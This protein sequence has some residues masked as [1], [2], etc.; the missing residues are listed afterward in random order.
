M[1]N[2]DS[3]LDATVNDANSGNNNVG[4]EIGSLTTYGFSRKFNGYISNL[5][6]VNGTALYTSSYSIPTARL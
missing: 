6:L 3:V 4:V 2:S 1:T 5:H